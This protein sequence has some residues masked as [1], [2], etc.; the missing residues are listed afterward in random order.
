MDRLQQITQQILALGI[1][2]DGVSEDGV[3]DFQDS[4]T[5]AQRALAQNVFDNWTEPTPTQLG[6]SL[7]VAQIA[8]S[9]LARKMLAGDDVSPYTEAQRLEVVEL[10][11]RYLL[12]GTDF[13][14]TLEARS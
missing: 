12:N 9:P 1:P 6:S 10:M 2:I 14:W 8:S 11:V 3:I 4:A 13:N 5:E 7:L